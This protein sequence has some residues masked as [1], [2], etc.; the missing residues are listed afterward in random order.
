MK[1]S[2]FTYVRNGLHFDYP[3]VES[4]QSVLPV[5]DEFIVVIG[6][7]FDGTREAVE[8]I[9]DPKIRI[10]DT[11]WDQQLRTGGKIFAEQANLGMEHAS[12]DSDW[13]FHIQADEL[14]HEKDVPAIREAMEKYLD[15]K[16][17]EGFLFKFI[18]FF[19]DYTHYGPSRRY[20][21]HEIRIVRN[22]PAIR[23]YRD[24]Q[25][26]RRFDN[27]ANQWEEKGHKLKVKTIDAT[28]YHYSFVKNPRKQLL[29]VIEFG[30]KWNETDDW[31]KK[32]LEEHPDGFDYG[33]ID[34]LA[35][36][37]GT[38][39]ATIQDRIRRQDWE[40]N[41]DPAKNNMSVKE[42]FMKWLQDLTGKQFFIY[43]NYELLD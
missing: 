28:I 26:F 18:N 8:A 29:R 17:V 1:V 32:Y 25:G 20:H 22:D 38:H 43:Q 24:S 6:D 36:F 4:I 30:N 3:I 39:P 42:K 33:Q 41:Y 12:R 5:V 21:Q 35:G 40:F 15:D 31:A 11:V 23:S 10:I 16:R 7:S 34:Y 19:G 37:T 2:A 14:I 13:L 27:P 9:R